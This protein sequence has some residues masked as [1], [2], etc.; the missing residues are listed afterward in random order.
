MASKYCVY[1][2]A[3]RR[4]GTLYTGITNNLARRVWEHREGQ[5]DGFTKEYDVKHLVYYETFDDIRAAIHRE[6]R[7]K[8]WKREWKINLIQRNNVEWKDLYES[9]RQ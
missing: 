2:L 5:I 9:L 4:N 1:I 7:L 3:S 6:S 8:K